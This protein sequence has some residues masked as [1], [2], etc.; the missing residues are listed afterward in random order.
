MV[1]RSK[2]IIKSLGPHVEDHYPSLP[3]Y[4]VYPAEDD[5]AIAIVIA[6]NKYSP[7]NFWY[8]PS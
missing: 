7:S 4:G 6:G 3:S 8:I 5:A 1:A 2:S